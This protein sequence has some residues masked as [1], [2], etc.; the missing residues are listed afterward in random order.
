MFL[1]IS[2]ENYIV[3]ISF[4]LVFI[5]LHKMIGMSASRSSG[6]AKSETECESSDQM[7][8]C[9]LWASVAAQAA[10]DAA[11]GGQPPV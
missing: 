8:L 5:S 1:L 4:R 6:K 9:S 11:A 7:K 3:G 2:T 10:E